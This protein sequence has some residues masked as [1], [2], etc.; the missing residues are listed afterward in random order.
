MHKRVPSPLVVVQ[1]CEVRRLLVPKPATQPHLYLRFSDSQRVG[2][3]PAGEGAHE[4]S[5]HCLRA[6]RPR[7]G[8][9]A[10]LAA[11][12][13]DAL[14]GSSSDTH[15]VRF[16]ARCGRGAG[17][18]SY[19]LR[20]AQRVRHPPSGGAIIVR[21]FGG[22]CAR[23]LGARWRVVPAEPT[24]P[25]SATAGVPRSSL[26]PPPRQSAVVIGHAS[27]AGMPLAAGA[28]RAEASDV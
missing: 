24:Q 21:R 2:K 17:A 1:I 13:R 22:D 7:T 6:A 8:P 28:P 10:C 19:L 9:G 14:C 18:H 26:I 20:P 23:C 27:V 5:G 3:R 25:C 12:R 16:A 15:A 11:G 4:T